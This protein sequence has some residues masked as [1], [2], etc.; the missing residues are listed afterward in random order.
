LVEDPDAFEYIGA[1]RVPRYAE[2]VGAVQRPCEYVVTSGYLGVAT[3]GVAERVAPE[4]CEKP[5]NGLETYVEGVRL[6]WD[7]VPTVVRAEIEA[8][9]AHRPVLGWASGLFNR[10]RVDGLFG[11]A[12]ALTAPDGRPVQAQAP[13]LVEGSVREVYGR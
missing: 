13:V 8:R 11:P 12:L 1:E 2:R 6:C 10:C 7:H 9:Y 5:S 4:R 3:D